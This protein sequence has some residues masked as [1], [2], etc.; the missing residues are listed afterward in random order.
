MTLT[1]NNCKILW[2]TAKDVLVHLYKMSSLPS[3]TCDKWRKPKL[4]IAAMWDVQL[5]GFHTQTSTGFAWSRLMTWLVRCA[6]RFTLLIVNVCFQLSLNRSYGHRQ[7]AGPP[8][9]SCWTALITKSESIDELSDLKNAFY[10]QTTCRTV[11]PKSMKCVWPLV[12]FHKNND[13]TTDYSL[14]KSSDYFF[15]YPV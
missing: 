11:K 4:Q 6:F 3:Q 8:H 14:K 9:F 1:I 5:E 10:P 7:K 12:L 13:P 15:H 2:K